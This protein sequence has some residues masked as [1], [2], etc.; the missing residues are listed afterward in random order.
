MSEGQ[1]VLLVEDLTTDGGSKLS[2]VDAIRE[3]GASCAHTA[4]IF[5]YDI[6]PET[7]KTSQIMVLACI[8]YAHGGM[9]WPKPRRKM[10]M[11]LAP[12]QRWKIPKQPA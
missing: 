5:Y 2:F 3:T 7:I 9:F 10:P 11:I 4:V 8:I 1:R 6:F 12:W